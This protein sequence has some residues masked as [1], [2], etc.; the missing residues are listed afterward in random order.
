MHQKLH[1]DPR[2]REHTTATITK[3]SHK[4]AIDRHEY[5]KITKIKQSEI[6]KKS[7]LQCVYALSRSI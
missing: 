3:C 4:F 2:E 5:Y 1:P 6:L 7:R